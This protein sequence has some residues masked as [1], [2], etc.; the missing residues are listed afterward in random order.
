VLKVE[1]GMNWLRFFPTADFCIRSV[2]TLDPA[3]GVTVF[4]YFPSFTCQT[5]LKK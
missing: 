2:E 3:N 4:L 1:G 5:K